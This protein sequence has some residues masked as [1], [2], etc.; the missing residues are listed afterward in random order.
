MQTQP[1]ALQEPGEACCRLLRVQGAETVPGLADKVVFQWLQGAAQ[2]LL[3]HGQEGG[4]GKRRQLFRRAGEPG[5]AVLVPQFLLVILQQHLGEVVTGGGAGHG[6][7]RV[8]QF[9]RILGCV[10]KV[11]Y[12]HQFVVQPDLNA[13]GPPGMVAD[14]DPGARGVALGQQCRYLAKSTSA[15][16]IPDLIAATVIG[17]CQVSTLLCVRPGPGKVLSSLRVA[18]QRVQSDAGIVMHLTCKPQGLIEMLPVLA[19]LCQPGHCLVVT[20][21][22]AVG[23]TRVDDGPAEQIPVRVLAGEENCDLTGAHGLLTV[24]QSYEAP[25]QRMLDFSLVLNTQALIC[26]Q[27]SGDLST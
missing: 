8:W 27:L 16:Q 25:A 1:P 4:L 13:L 6:R 14:L 10:V 26:E 21:C 7:L 17:F 5:L 15:H 24:T 11:G 22:H 3:K 2:R 19:E 23:T 9:G 12:L 20:T 18:V